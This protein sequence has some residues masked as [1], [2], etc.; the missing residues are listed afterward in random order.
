M[1]VTYERA[2]LRE[3]RKQYDLIR[4]CLAGEVTIKDA[5]YRE[6]YLPMPNA[7]DKSA[8]NMMRYEA[9]VRR[10]VFYNVTR[11]T[12]AGMVGQVFLEAPV[13]N[14]PTT[15]SNVMVDDCDGTGISLEQSLTRAVDYTLA[16]SRCGLLA[17]YPPNPDG[18]I[19][20]LA[21]LEDGDVR[22]TI[23]VYQ[24][25][26]IINW[27]TVQKGARQIL[28]L[29]VLREK[30]FGVGEDGFSAQELLQYRVLRIDP[31]T[32][33]HVAQLWVEPNSEQAKLAATSEA[34]SIHPQTA[35]ATKKGKLVALPEYTPLNA[36]G[37][38]LDEIPFT[39]CGAT[40]NDPRPEVPILY[41]MASLNLAHYRNSAD[42]EESVFVVGQPTP[43][44]TGLTQEWLDQVLKGS[45]RM[46][47]TGGI[48]LPIGAGIGLLEVAPNSM[49]MEAMTHKEQQM[50]ALGAK[51]VEPQKTGGRT[52][53]EALVDHDT[54]SSVLANISK[55]VSSAFTKAMMWCAGFIDVADKSIKITLSKDFDLA[56]M[57]AQDRG[58]LLKEWTSGA[59]S[60]PEYR[61]NL[62]SG[63]LL[64]E[65]DKQAQEEIASE[66]AAQ[67]ITLLPQADPFADSAK[68]PAG[69]AA[70][71]GG[72]PPGA[73]KPNGAA[74]KP[75][76]TIAKHP[77]GEKA[78]VA[79]AN[80]K[81][82]QTT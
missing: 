34:A 79:G 2:E 26:D 14:L 57:N 38:P 58:Q 65:D 11:R 40:S 31:E 45:L 59:I 28:S 72:G 64:L 22:P 41:D 10:A 76:P 46:G 24:P 19:A 67:T 55:N 62:R 5:L 70:P 25:W 17:D 4:D 54:E 8:T 27:R 60:W 71:P 16:Y 36:Q 69:G 6:R 44:V 9:Y 1:D 47:S 35:D 20:T 66:L 61:A 13:I 53:T 39:F 81:T 32:G 77:G 51:L 7:A 15:L 78:A 48:P 73:G 30:N 29:V 82:T 56:K 3:L 12:H 43:W 42:Y 21:E 68:P 23:T 50:L 33:N 52:A 63:G 49:A 75:Q 74:G 80:P 18:V 37:V